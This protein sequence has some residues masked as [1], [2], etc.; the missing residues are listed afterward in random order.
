L[1]F[2]VKACRFGRIKKFERP[3]SQKINVK[4][5]L[6]M[7]SMLYID[8]MMK[9]IFNRPESVQ[10][11]KNYSWR[12]DMKLNAWAFV[13][14]FIAFASRSWLHHHGDE[15]VLLR[16]A[17]ALSP[18]LPSLFYVSTVTH[19]IRG[20]DEMQRRIQMEACL[21]ATVGTTFVATALSLLQA[22]ALL[23]PRWQGGL[24]WEGMFALVV[25]FYFLGNVLI[26]RRYQ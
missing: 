5:A 22:N 2:T 9:N 8:C 16:A 4:D 1:P 12:A 26:N 19:W 21:F 11:G 10:L 15:P 20:M 17:I 13:A 6:H 14:V 18:L 3:Q 25:A 7:E 24:G 23:P